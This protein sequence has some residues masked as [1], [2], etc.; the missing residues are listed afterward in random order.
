MLCGCGCECDAPNSFACQVVVTYQPYS[1]VPHS[2]SAGRFLLGVGSSTAMACTSS[3]PSDVRSNNTT[4]A[5][6]VAA[7]LSTTWGTGQ[8]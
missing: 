4:T 3:L 6:L 5:G 7:N 1:R 2:A 8:G